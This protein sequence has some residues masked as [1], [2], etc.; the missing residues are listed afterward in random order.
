M[1]KIYWDEQ[2]PQELESR[3]IMWKNEMM[4]ISYICLD[5]CYGFENNVDV[6]VEI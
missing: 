4:K 5:R 2:I 1:L 3:W 6:R